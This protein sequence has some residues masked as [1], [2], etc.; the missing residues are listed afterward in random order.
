M[1]VHR[2]ST[3][4]RHRRVRIPAVHQDGLCAEQQRAFERVDGPADVCDRGGHQ[5]GV[6][7][8]DAPV[9]AEL[10]DQCAQRLMA[11]QNTFRTSRGAGGVHD[12]PGGG[13]VRRGQWPVALLGT[14]TAQRQAPRL[15]ADDDDLRRGRQGGDHPVQHR[16]VVVTAESVRDED[17]AATCVGEDERQLAVAQRRQ[18]RVDHHA[19]QRR[20][21]VDDCGLVPVRHHERHHAARRH[22]VQQHLRQT[23]RRREQ[24]R[25]AQRYCAVPQQHPV[26]GV[27]GGVPQRVGQEDTHDASRLK[28]DGFTR[29]MVI[30]CRNLDD[31]WVFTVTWAISPSE[32]V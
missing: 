29:R 31:G 19:G 5:E 17:D 1:W 30:A 8:V 6:A 16:G 15:T 11:V 24:L 9:R 7:R 20:A 26:R 27:T 12:H 23:R 22:P 21:E 2:C 13:R 4:Q 28:P 25:A 32:V 10:T 3:H 18:D 14:Q